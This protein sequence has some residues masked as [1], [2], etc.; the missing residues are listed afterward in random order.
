VDPYE[1]NEALNLYDK[2][3]MKG[4]VPQVAAKEFKEVI[5]KRSFFEKLAV[6]SLNEIIFI[7]LA[8]IAFLKSDSNYTTIVSSDNKQITSSKNLGYYESILSDQ[9]FLRIH[10]SYMV[11]VPKIVRFIK[12]KTGSVVLD[13]GHTL[14][15]T[16][17][18]REELMKL[19][20]I[21]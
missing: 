10:N 7:S 6:P 2:E 4:V 13:S 1:L 9:G 3:R 8:N 15:V 16:A 11:N 20:N 5:A 21:G 19:L 12:G 17:S 18:R 14:E